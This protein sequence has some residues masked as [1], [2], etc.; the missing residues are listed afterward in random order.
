MRE[1][2]GGGDGWW[3]GMYSNLEGTKKTWYKIQGS[4][5][6]DKMLRLDPGVVG[7]RHF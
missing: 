1:G 2:N 4:K 5:R 7:L 6:F 3:K